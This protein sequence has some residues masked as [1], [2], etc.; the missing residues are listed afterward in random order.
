MMNKPPRIINSILWKAMTKQ[1]YFL[2]SFYSTFTSSESHQQQYNRSY[3]RGKYDV[4][5]MLNVPQLEKTVAAT[6]IT[7]PPHS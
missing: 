2:I 3:T 5:C 4:L 1:K 6:A 7:T